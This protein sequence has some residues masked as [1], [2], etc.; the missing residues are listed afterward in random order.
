MKISEALQ[1]LR[2]GAQWTIHD[3][4]YEKLEW[5]DSIQSKPTADEINAALAYYTYIAAR[6]AEYP[7]VGD[8]LDAIWKGGAAS[9]QMKARIVDI[10]NKYPKG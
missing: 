2:P 8:Q 1:I 7:S 5:L 4:A 9:D 3:D 6:V 10:K